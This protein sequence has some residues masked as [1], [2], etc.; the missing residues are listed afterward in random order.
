LNLLPTFPSQNL[1]V[2]LPPG[3]PIRSLYISNSLVKSIIKH[4]DYQKLRLTAAGTKGASI[5][6]S[7]LFT[8]LTFF[9]QIV[10]TKQE[11]GKGVEASYRVLG[12]GLPVV[13]PFIEPSS[14]LHGSLKTL[15]TFLTSYYPLVREF[16][17]EF[18][19]QIDESCAYLFCLYPFMFWMGR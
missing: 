11:A 5:A 4:N 9:P 7:Q 8:S 10:F 16:E 19:S 1:L 6:V 12:E 13:L 17:E 15:R 2:R 3:E 14:I 18:R